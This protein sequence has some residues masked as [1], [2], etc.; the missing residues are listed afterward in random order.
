MSQAARQELE[1]FWGQRLKDAKL[2]LDLARNYLNEVQ[3][4][5]KS[6]SIPS[7]DR[8]HAYQHALRAEILAVKCFRRVLDTFNALSWRR[9]RD[10]NPRASYPANGFQDRRLRPLGHSSISKLS[11]FPI[12]CN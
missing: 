11:D 4:D 10:S 12:T 5:L 7:P 6:G 2:R 9:K 8:H 1:D 3:S